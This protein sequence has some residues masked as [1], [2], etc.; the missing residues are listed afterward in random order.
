MTY[1]TIRLDIA[2]GIATIT[3]NR[4]ERLNAMS[5]EMGDELSDALLHLDGARALLI[6]GE[7][8]AFCSGADLAARGDNRPALFLGY[9]DVAGDVRPVRTYFDVHFCHHLSNGHEKGRC[10]ASYDAWHRPA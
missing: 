9:I 10:P 5:V 7:G 3:L 8:R 2:D 4:P 1:E 6:T